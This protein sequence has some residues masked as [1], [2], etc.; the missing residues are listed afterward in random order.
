VSRLGERLRQLRAERTLGD[1]ERATGIARI[2]IS[3]YERG[4]RVPE[5]H[6]LKKLAAHYGVPYKELRMLHVEDMYSS[7][8]EEREIVLEWAQH[9]LEN[10]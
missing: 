6:M 8:A 2:V 4:Q 3:R 9:V 10:R 5:S 7:D 1:I